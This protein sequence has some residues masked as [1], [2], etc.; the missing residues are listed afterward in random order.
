MTFEKTPAIEY[1]EDRNGEY[2]EEMRF[3]G[4]R[5]HVGD[6]FGFKGEGCPYEDM[7]SEDLEFLSCKCA[8]YAGMPMSVDW[9]E[10]DEEYWLSYGRAG[11]V[12]MWDKQQALY[13][14]HEK[15]VNNRDGK[16]EVIR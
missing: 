5:S 10:D 6:M 11:H 12:F 2:L 7:E 14:R 16:N 8:P 15:F 4:E 3:R 13:A 9:T 1:L